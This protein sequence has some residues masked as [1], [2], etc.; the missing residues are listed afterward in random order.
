MSAPAVLVVQNS[1]TSGLRRFETW[2]RQSGLRLDVRQGADGLPGTPDGYDGLVLLGGGL[3]PSDDERAPW[4][5]A[6]RA[7]T[8]A[9][10]ERG[11]PT[12]GICLG[13]QLLAE[14]AGGRVT[15]R[16]GR[17]ER[18]STTIGLTDAASDDP[19]FAGLPRTVRM[20]ENHEDSITALPAG[21]VLLAS[22]RD[23]PH[24]AFR[25][26]EHAWGLQFHPEVAAAELARWNAAELAAGGL[27][28]DRLRREADAA[29]PRAASVARALADGFARVVAATV[30]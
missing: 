23:H 22:S 9:A 12:L 25:V 26:G 16:H 24:Q 19:L 6:E 18:G 5:P 2:W 1:A 15:A 4:L 10:L 27:D 3:L 13:G 21:A 8:A 7:L 29:E 11:L 28:L 30:A 14:V 17:P 20:I